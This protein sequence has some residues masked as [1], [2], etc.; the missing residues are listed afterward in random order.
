MLLRAQAAERPGTPPPGGIPA[1][2]AVLAGIAEA[3]EQQYACLLDGDLARFTALLSDDNFR[4]NVGGLDPREV[5]EVNFANPIRLP[6]PLYQIDQVL[7]LPDG[8]IMVRIQRERGPTLHFYVESNGGYLLDGGFELV[9][10]ST[11]TPAP[12]PEATPTPVAVQETTQPLNQ[13]LVEPSECRAEPRPLADFFAL[14]EIT[15]TSATPAPRGSGPP[16]A[17]GVPA[18]PLVVAE[19]REAVR[20]YTACGATRDTRL[21]TALWTDDFVRRSLAGL[22]LETLSTTASSPPVTARVPEVVSVRVLPDRR[23]L[24]E[25]RFANEREFIAFVV[26]D[27]R[28]LADDLYEPPDDATPV[29]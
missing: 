24:V 25:T 7:V 27:G 29:P 10:A 17:G 23:V 3:I 5:V 16:P 2:P 20:H 8:R 28:Y 21:I 14:A 9:E 15:P 6:L 18:A 13:D 22:D 1:N 19:A 12:V 26:E 11:A 4:R